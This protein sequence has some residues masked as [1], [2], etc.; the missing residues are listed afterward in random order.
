M[1]VGTLQYMYPEQVEGKEADAR[2]DIF[3]LGAVL[4]EMITGRPAFEGKSQ[5]GVVSAILQQEPSP[6]SSTS[7]TC[8]DYLIRTCLAKDPEE[9]FQ[10]AHAVKLQLRWLQQSS[11]IAQPVVRATRW[12]KVLWPIAALAILLAVL[13]ILWMSQPRPRRDW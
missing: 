4:Y 11:G 2:S 10:T 6:V 3:A 5:V 13:G 9:R 12:R 1:L 8:L 7:S